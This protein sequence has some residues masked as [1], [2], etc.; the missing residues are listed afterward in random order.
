MGKF[1]TKGYDKGLEELNWRF[2]FGNKWSTYKELELRK[3]ISW[4]DE[5]SRNET[6]AKRYI[7]I[8]TVDLCY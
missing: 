2:V 7:D 5:R 6:T 4:A 8:R 3:K 1:D